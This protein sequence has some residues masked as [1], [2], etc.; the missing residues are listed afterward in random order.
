MR[1]LRIGTAG[2]SI[3][4]QFPATA[5]HGT[6]LVRYSEIFNCAEINSSFNRSHRLSTWKK[7]A[8]SVPNDFC[9][10]VKAPKT[11]T[12]EAKLACT[13]AQLQNFLTEANA[14]GDKL[15]TIL[16]QLPPNSI[17]NPTTAKTFFTM[18]R[19]LYSRNCVIEPRHATW[20]TPDV[21]DLLQS[22][23]IARVAA[24]PARVPQA[25]YAAGWGELIYC[26][27]HGSPRI[28]YSPYPEGYLRSLAA[29]FAAHPTKEIWCIFDNTVF[30][31][32]FGNAQCLKHFLA[33]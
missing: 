30:G 1:S 10:S 9:F 17:F 29:S 26:R 19:D 2:W 28:Y 11:I 12:H 31:A 16:F 33:S 27:L 23:R 6:H 14:L 21:D 24:D 7:W 4:K 25:A 18:L 8:N 15:G 3:P 22:F 13:Q 32:A 20:F 5:P